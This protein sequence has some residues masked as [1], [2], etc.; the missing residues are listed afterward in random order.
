MIPN[1]GTIKVPYYEW[2]LHH[3][4]FRKDANTCPICN[5]DSGCLARCP[6]KTINDI[7]NQIGHLVREYD[8]GLR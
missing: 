5:S 8:K 7:L 4:P 6:Y 2:W 3:H 1:N